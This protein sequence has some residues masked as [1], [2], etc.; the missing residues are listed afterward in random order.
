MAS[1]VVKKMPKKASRKTTDAHSTFP[2]EA[3]TMP[4]LELEA[5]TGN[6]NTTDAH[7]T[8]PIE[9]DMMPPLELQATIGN[10]DT[11]DAPYTMPP[12]ELEATIGNTVENELKELKI[13]PLELEATIRN[14]VE[15]ELKELKE[16]VPTTLKPNDEH[17][18]LSADKQYKGSVGVVK[19]SK[20]L[21][22]SKKN[23]SHE[24]KG[25][26]NAVTCASDVDPFIGKLVAIDLSSDYG[27]EL[28][29]M[30]GFKLMYDAVN[31]EMNSDAGHI[32]GTVMRKHN[33]TNCYE[34]VW[35]FTSL[36]ETT[37][38]LS[39]VLDGHKEAERLSHT[40]QSSSTKAKAKAIRGKKV[41]KDNIDALL[42][43]LSE[44]E[45]EKGALSSD[46]SVSDD[47]TTKVKTIQI[48]N[49]LILQ[50]LQEKKKP[51]QKFHRHVMK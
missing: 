32:L 14:T 8:F 20:K 49:S 37:V 16:V 6:T 31:F 36:G 7:S 38:P 23:K 33:K 22:T 29:V 44:D 25:K 1:T 30:F 27:K 48:G 28:M 43:E 9:A 45:E 42:K 19:I 46:G 15:N 18:N 39:A 4:P 34:V 10:T 3:E 50:I 5:S 21:I 17:V 47:D 41:N 51:M 11:A 13:P 24:V 12:L 35:Q 40:R 2:I 26:N